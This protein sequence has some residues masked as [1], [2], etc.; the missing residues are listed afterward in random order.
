MPL[1]SCYQFTWRPWPVFFAEAFISHTL[2][3]D[4]VTNAENVC[5]GGNLDQAFFCFPKQDHICKIPL[6]RRYATCRPISHVPTYTRATIWSNRVGARSCTTEAVMVAAVAFIYI[7]NRQ[8][9]QQQVIICSKHICIEN[10][11]N[12]ENRH[13][14]SRARDINE[15]CNMGQNNNT[16]T[17]YG[18]DATRAYLFAHDTWFTEQ[19]R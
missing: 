12:L 1:K 15:P 6:T 5:L 14:W 16:W 9:Q 7:Y 4:C 13:A 8:Q 19:E 3:Q 18:E 17:G 10:C 2:F 11:N